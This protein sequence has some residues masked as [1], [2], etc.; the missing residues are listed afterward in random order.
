MVLLLLIE[1]AAGGLWVTYASHL[2]G[3]VTRGFLKMGAATVLTS[4]LVAAWVATAIG[5]AG[6]AGGYPLDDRLLNPARFTLWALVVLTALYTLLVWRER[7]PSGRIAG[8]VSSLAAVA[9]L[10]LAAGIFRLPAWGYAGVLF[11]LVAGSL[12][13]GAVTLG[14]VLGHWYL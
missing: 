6:A 7:E 9:A 1:F 14:M 11:S 5:G 13:L 8:A 12:S 10:A 3:L 2:R 4:G